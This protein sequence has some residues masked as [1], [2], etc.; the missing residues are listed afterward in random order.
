MGAE[1]DGA[2]L[3]MFPLRNFLKLWHWIFEFW[4]KLGMASLFWGF[5]TC[6]SLRL[7]DWVGRF[8]CFF[9]RV[10]GFKNWPNWKGEEIRGRIGDTGWC[11]SVLW[12]R[13]DDF[14]SFCHVAFVKIHINFFSWRRN[15]FW[16]TNC[17]TWEHGEFTYNFACFL[18]DM[19]GVHY[20][21]P[22][23]LME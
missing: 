15:F 17:S 8:G 19:R 6:H 18:N 5:P 7:P 9:W 3:F 23:E 21:T 11:V 4:R 2:W 20:Y 16:T 12:S 22:C 10:P 13:M 1:V 14:S